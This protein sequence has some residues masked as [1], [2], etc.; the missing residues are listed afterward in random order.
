MK[1]VVIDNYDSFT[2]N[3]V[4]YLEPLCNEVKVFRN[5]EVTAGQ[6]ADYDRIVYSPGPGLPSEANIMYDILQH[7]GS[8]KPIL[9]ICLGHQA[10]VEFFGGK[11]SNLDA[12]L[13]G[14]NIPSCKTSKDEAFF[15][16]VPEQFETGRYHSWGVKKHDLPQSLIATATD[17]YDY[18]MG[19]THR[20]LNIRGVQ[21]H[22][23]SV[24]TPHGRTMLKNWIAYC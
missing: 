4:H 1:I 2:Y 17:T 9:G 21:F 14:R 8:H 19:L 15:R 6:L 3:L 10:I 16:S 24:L 22:P 7:W 23:E 13:H 20:S 5:N 12:P 11:L 18:V